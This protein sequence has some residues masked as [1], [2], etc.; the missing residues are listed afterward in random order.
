MCRNTA[1]GGRRCPSCVDQDKRSGHN[2]AAYAF[3]AYLNQQGGPLPVLEAQE[4]KIT[5]PL[6]NMPS[7]EELQLLNQE[8]QNTQKHKE[9]L[10]ILRQH[11]EL[12][13]PDSPKIPTPAHK[14][15]IRIQEAFNSEI[16]LPDGRKMA[17]TM[18]SIT[19]T[20]GNVCV[21]GTLHSEIEGEEE[22]GLESVGNWV[23]TFVIEKNQTPYANYKELT[24]DSDFQNMRL[25]QKLL[26]HFDSI[27]LACGI[28]KVTMEANLDIGGYAWAKAG[29]DWDTNTGTGE[30]PWVLKN[31]HK[32]QRTLA[33]MATTHGDPNDE[34]K[35]MIT[36][37]NKS[38]S[39]NYPTPLEV[40]M[41]GRSNTFIG[42]AS[43]FDMQK[44]SEM[45]AGKKA[46]LGST[47]G[48]VRKLS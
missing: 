28:T 17:V 14:V 23:R 38:Y 27:A 5:T 37:L 44:K 29:Y 13:N 8:L 24:I 40:A 2:R 36:R 34:I 42:V 35:K 16:T 10:S 47:W 12:G 33:L 19:F 20:D 48:G 45:W 3:R 9:R 4:S 25:G 6:V 22:E 21:A 7:V 32:I 26:A 31:E 15:A 30:E 1:E 43:I 41:V 39:P 46:L 11:L 18:D